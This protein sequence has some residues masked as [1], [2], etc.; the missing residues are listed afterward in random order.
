MSNQPVDA[1]RRDFVAGAVTV[2]ARRRHRERRA[3]ADAIEP[4]LLQ[5]ARNVEAGGL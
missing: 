5:P 4:A 2:A 3:S 1:S